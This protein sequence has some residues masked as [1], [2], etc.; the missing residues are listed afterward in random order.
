MTI[1]DANTVSN[2]ESVNQIM[3]DIL[4]L[5]SSEIAEARHEQIRGLIKA[6]INGDVSK[7]HVT[8][9]A[10]LSK[11]RK[12]VLVYILTNLRLIKIEID[13]KEI[14]SSSFSLDKMI[15]FD[16]TLV[17]GDRAGVKVSFQNGSLGLQYNQTEQKITDFFQQVDQSRVREQP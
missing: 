10:N 8:T 11:D 3:V 5:K 14:H 13:A 1:S 9:T 16:R 15:A 6:T 4:Q 7:T 2:A 12:G 17:D